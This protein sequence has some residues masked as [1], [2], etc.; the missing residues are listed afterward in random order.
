MHDP[1]WHVADG[2]VSDKPVILK[3][4]L[5]DG[6]CRSV[7]VRPSMPVRQVVQVV[8]AKCGLSHELDLHGV[9][10]QRTQGAHA[11]PLDALALE[12]LGASVEAVYVH[13]LA[14]PA[15][16]TGVEDGGHGDMYGLSGNVPGPASPTQ[17]PDD[18]TYDHIPDFPVG[19][20]GHEA[21]YDERTM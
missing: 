16:H 19:D 15:R 10:V 8:L 18:P 11:V 3:V 2:A 13:P 6:S 9:T 5:E 1:V 20:G 21:H 12:L 4:F 17:D 14:R 7:R